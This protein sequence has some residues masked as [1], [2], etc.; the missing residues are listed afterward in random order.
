MHTIELSFFPSSFSKWTFKFQFSSKCIETWH[1]EP[2]LGGIKG[3]VIAIIKSVCI[4]D[5]L[6]YHRSYATGEALKDGQFLS[7]WY[8]SQGKRFTAVPVW[9]EKITSWTNARSCTYQRE[10]WTI[11]VHWMIRCADFQLS[12]SAPESWPITETEHIHA[13]AKSYHLTF[14]C[15]CPPLRKHQRR[16]VPHVCSLLQKQDTCSAPTSSSERS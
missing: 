9:G 15:W 5:R 6:K 2:S 8:L 14:C 3:R 7:V 4:P 12:A 1:S 10:K 11:V 16:K 13:P